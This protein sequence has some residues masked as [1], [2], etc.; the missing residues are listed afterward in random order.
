MG[1]FERKNY[2][3]FW[4]R[5]FRFRAAAF[6]K[7][8]NRGDKFGLSTSKAIAMTSGMMLQISLQIVVPLGSRAQELPPA[9]HTL[10]ANARSEL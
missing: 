4:V 2:Y 3:Y 9:R 10:L 8:F 5:C 1:L 6:S 7:V